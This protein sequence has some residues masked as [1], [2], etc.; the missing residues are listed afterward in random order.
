MVRCPTHKGEQAYHPDEWKFFVDHFQLAPERHRSHKF[1]HGWFEW[2]DSVIERMGTE[3]LIRIAPLL[4]VYGGWATNEYQVGQKVAAQL[5]QREVTARQFIRGTRGIELK[6]LGPETAHATVAYCL[7]LKNKKESA[8]YAWSDVRNLQHTGKER[9]EINRQRA[10]QLNQGRVNPAS[11]EMTLELDS[12]PIALTFDESGDLYILDKD[13]HLSVYREGSRIAGWEIE[14]P[15]A[16]GKGFHRFIEELTQKHSITVANNMVVLTDGDSTVYSFQRPD[17]ASGV[18]RRYDTKKVLERGVR[19]HDTLAVNG[20]VFLSVSKGGRDRPH[21]HQVISINSGDEVKYEGAFPTSFAMSPADDMTMRLGAF[22]GNVYFPRGH[23]LAGIDDSGQT[24]QYLGD[25]KTHTDRLGPLHPSSK[26]AF[27]DNFLVVQAIFD[28]F[29]ITP[30]Q[31][32][33]RPHYNETT[34]PKRRDQINGPL[35]SRFDLLH[36][37]Y[38]QDSSMDVIC[39]AVYAAHGNLFAQVGPER[40]EVYIFKMK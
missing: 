23:I 35:P 4:A 11:L 29:G 18:I 8:S 1:G 26:F 40:K 3:D 28:G 22:D 17:A 9:F 31:A 19:I 38:P 6:L 34:L 36:I 16:F 21:V 5:V 15:E 30:M 33:F 13:S 20:Q 10:D 24:Q 12:E 2:D 37:G 7:E 32:I 25:L 27:G 39:D 14:F